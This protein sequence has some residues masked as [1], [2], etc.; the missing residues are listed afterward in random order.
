M[1]M[2]AMVKARSACR[3]KYLTGGAVVAYGVP[4]LS[5]INNDYADS[6]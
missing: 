3:L 6:R 1:L 4:V 5:A 2:R